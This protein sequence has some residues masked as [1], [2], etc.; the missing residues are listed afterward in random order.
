[1]GR[2]Q[3]RHTQAISRG[4]H[5]ADRD[6]LV[7]DFRHAVQ[8]LRD[9]KLD[10]SAEAHR[11]VLSREPNHAPSLLNLG[12]IA[13]KTRARS[14]AVD[15]IRRSLQIDPESRDGWLNL[16][17]VLAEAKR[18]DEAIAACRQCLALSPNDA[19]AHSVLGSLLNATR[20][21][22]D[23]VQ[24]YA[25]ALKADPD[26]PAVL[27]KMAKL[28]LQ[29][30]QAEEAMTLCRRA[31]EL[32]PDLAEAGDLE[33]QILSEGRDL[34]ASV[35]FIV[36]QTQDARE[37]ARLYDGLARSLRAQRRFR[38]AI[39]VQR[40]ALA[41]DNAQPDFHFN[42][43]AALDGAGQRRD[44]LTAYQQGLSIAPDRADGYARVGVLLRKMDAHE[45]AVTAFRESVRLDPTLVD[46]HYNLAITLKLLRRLN[47]A[48]EALDRA[49]M[50]APDSVVIRFERIH[51]MR[52]S[53]DW[54]GLEEEEQ[55]AIEM[56]RASRAPAAPFLML[57]LATTRADQLSAGQR[58]T[59]VLGVPATSR[60]RDYPNASKP[61]ERIR[62]GYLSADFCRHATAMLIAEVLEK[63][64]RSRFELIGYC[65]SPDDGSEIRSRIRSA[66]DRF[67]EIR[68]MSDED[69]AKKIHDDGIDVLVD[70]KGYT[71]DARTAILAMKPAP[72]QVNY[73]GYPG[74]M[75]GDF[76]DY[77]VGDATITPM[78]HQPDYSERIV[79]LPHCYQP[80]DRQRVISDVPMTRAGQ[81]LPDD[82]FVFCSFNNNYKISPAMFRI[83]MRL[84]VQV[85]GSVLWT[86]VKNPE[87]RANLLREAE[88]QGVAPER[89][90][91]AEPLPNDEHLARHR[92]ADLFLDTSPC[93]AHTTASDAL[94]AGLPV[95][96]LLG[97]TFA[98]RV[99]ASL[100]TAMDLPELIA[101]TPDD[102]EHRA[103]TLARD[104]SRLDA[105]RERIA[106][107][108]RTS[109]LFD[110]TRYARNLEQAY[111]TM[112]NIMR[113]GEA[114]RPFAVT[115]LL[116]RMGAEVET[117]APETAP[118]LHIAYDQ[119]PVCD[120]T[121]IPYQIEA[122]VSEHGLYKPELPPTVKWRAC[123]DCGHF[124]T[125]GAFTSEAREI[126]A[127]SCLPEQEVGH[128]A[129]RRRKISARIV[130]R[131]ARHVPAGEWLDIGTG[132][133]SLLFTAAEWGY[134][135][136]GMDRRIDTVERLLKLGY[137]AF[138]ND[139][140]VIEQVEGADR[141]NVVSIAGSLPRAPFPKQALAAVHRLLRPR[142]ALFLSMPNM[143][144]IEWRILDATR[145]NPY[146]SEIEH[147]HNFT[148]ARVAR[149]LEAQGFRVAEYHV[150][151]DAPSVMELIAIKL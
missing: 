64:D 93:N 144:T 30:N 2:K 101:E 33:R 25:N 110:S 35:A 68:G 38:E 11:R 122:R 109:P 48:R 71:L 45:G 19:K 151:E 140:A 51:L 105:I 36:S 73:L 106:E 8:L 147:H 74:S 10:Q 145:S 90:V 27:V 107:G 67:V 89:I 22:A 12:L 123:E 81:G 21:T 150:G 53:C 32:A 3:R 99:A 46:G 63:T 136:V 60:Y 34:E 72:I 139:I 130:E 37:L 15:Y 111:E 137:K 146:W 103:L 18:L 85:P 41:H 115:D 143:D 20:N 120:G 57:P 133:G 77:I 97:E 40:R 149:M 131:V 116:A 52:M 141:F 94:W 100:L 80:N 129:G 124:F 118:I 61:G 26:Q 79:Q 9:G 66:F 148:R 95:V 117:A 31:L 88:A 127:S 59:E 1:M 58:F 113:T 14:D 44:A 126:V 86:L 50:C 121:D 39:A 125:E 65:F 28:L 69:A 76:M 29:S 84:L 4:P 104:R 134:D 43:A 119:C 62:I 112:V 16:A 114:P 13:F 55:R 78:A 70:L 56:L 23:A 128:E 96:T 75:G 98:G 17:I 142:G 54:R 6:P 132:N 49:V 7:R 82:A 138:W 83:W 102:Y 42:L 5:A 135:V 47:E 91:F 108:C 87:C 92:L 24:A